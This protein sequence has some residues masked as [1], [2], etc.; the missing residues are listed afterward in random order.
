LTSGDVI[1]QIDRKPVTSADQFRNDV[2][3]APADK[4]MLLTVWSNGGSS[5]RIV[6]PEAVSGSNGE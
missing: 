3:E 1:Q 5:Y 6:H 4:D 2:K